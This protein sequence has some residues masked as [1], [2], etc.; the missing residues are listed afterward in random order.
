MHEVQVIVK[1]PGSRPVAR[2]IVIDDSSQKPQAKSH[3]PVQAQTS[4]TGQVQGGGGVYHGRRKN[5]K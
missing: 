2:V 3:V 4:W 5:R 1:K